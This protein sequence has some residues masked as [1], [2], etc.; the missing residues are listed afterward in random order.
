MERP[1][2]VVTGAS[3]RVGQNVV[4]HLLRRQYPHIR[5]AFHHV[6]DAA[7]VPE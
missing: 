6:S 7:R 5:A 2:I 1:L 4:S 3:G